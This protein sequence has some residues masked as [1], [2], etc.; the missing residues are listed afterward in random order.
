LSE[1]LVADNGT[2]KLGN[3]TFSWSGSNSLVEAEL[4]VFGMFDLTIGKISLD[5]DPTRRRIL[6]ETRFVSC[7]HGQ[8][9]L[10]FNLVDGKPILKKIYKHPLD[11]TEFAFVFR[12]SDKIFNNV[13]VGDSISALKCGAGN[14]HQ[15]DEV[16][17]AS[18]SLGKSKAELVK[19]LREQLLYPV[20]S[21]PKPMSNDYLKSWN[22]V[23]ETAN[24]IIF[25]IND[26]R[27]KIKGQEGM[28]VFEL[29]DVLK[30]RFDYLW[31]CVG[32]SGQSSK[33]LIKS[34][35][36]EIYGNMHYQNYRG[37]A[38]TWDG[39]NGRPVPV[40]LLAYE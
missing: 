32:D 33:L 29:Q 31:A 25:Y 36:A 35:I 18:F 16:C 21:Q 20:G 14:F 9:L 26:A 6:K 28:S 11:L 12:G 17:S 34:D 24:N 38:P 10:G 15:G 4:T 13:K 8:V 30:S 2:L 3:I 40:A 1:L 5:S 7:N 22:V 39:N 19:N 37:L 27:P 23:M